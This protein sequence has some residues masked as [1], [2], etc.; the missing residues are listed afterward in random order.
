M[1][2]KAK[3]FMHRYRYTQSNR[4]PVL[5]ARQYLVN[6]MAH[7]RYRGQTAPAVRAA[8]GILN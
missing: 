7:Q 3:L 6:D 4:L 2:G 1:R 8:I 5:R